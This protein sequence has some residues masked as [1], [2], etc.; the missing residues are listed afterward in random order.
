MTGRKGRGQNA[1]GT[2][3]VRHYAPRLLPSALCP[4]HLPRRAFTLIEM[5]TTVAVLIIVL[6]LMVSLA[7]YVRDRSAQ[8]LTRELLR[9][10]DVLMGQYIKN[11][12][13]RMPPV[14]LLLPPDV[15]DPKDD[16]ALAEAAKRNNA[17]FVSYLKADYRLQLR[18]PAGPPDPFDRQPIS[19]YDRRTLRDAWGSPVVFMSGQH[20]RIGLAPSVSG[21]DQFFFFSAGPDRKYL[22]R[23]DNLYSYETT[24][25][26]EGLGASPAPEP[27]RSG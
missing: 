5:L 27:G 10:L 24:A 3:A 13:K 15:T 9:E 2:T 14:D 1:E 6:G 25:M 20:P 21:Q 12:D 18:E 26:G 19:V 16:S 7:R 8:Q 11:N 22:T 4:H 23:D 17:Q